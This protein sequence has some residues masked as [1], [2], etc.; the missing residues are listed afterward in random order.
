MVRK[1]EELSAPNPLIG[2]L[3]FLGAVEKSSFNHKEHKVG[4]K[5]TKLKTYN[6]ASG[7]GEINRGKGCCLIKPLN[8]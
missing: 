6:S 2:E 3:C 4:S 8:P 5:C 7:K 1:N